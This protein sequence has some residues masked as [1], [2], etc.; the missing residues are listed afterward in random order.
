MLSGERDGDDRDVL[1][2]H[3]KHVSL[4]DRRGKSEAKKRSDFLPETPRNLRIGT[5]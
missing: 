3:S 4:S 1:A 2:C 5:L